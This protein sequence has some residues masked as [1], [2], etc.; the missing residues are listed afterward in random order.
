MINDIG[1]NKEVYQ[2]G[3]L[4]ACF[5]SMNCNSLII[6][7]ENHQKTSLVFHVTCVYCEV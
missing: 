1:E 6:T 4:V 7:S 5:Y 3:K 2:K